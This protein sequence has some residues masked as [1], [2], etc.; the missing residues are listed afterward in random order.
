MAEE[1]C[2]SAADGGARAEQDQ[3]EEA[4]DGGRQD[5]RECGESFKCGEPAA[6]AEDQQCGKG[7]R[8]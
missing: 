4:E 1:G 7:N 2:D 5:K 8:R 3:Q 6:A